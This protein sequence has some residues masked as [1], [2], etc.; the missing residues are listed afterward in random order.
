MTEIDKE[1][2][3]DAILLI[4]RNDIINLT[5]LKPMGKFSVSIEVNMTQGAIGDM[6]LDNHSR[7]KYK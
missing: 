6:Y 5:K 1:Q 7:S 4:A 3:I 2:K